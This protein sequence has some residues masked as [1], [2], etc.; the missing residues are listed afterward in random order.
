MCDGGKNHHDEIWNDDAQDANITRPRL[1]QVRTEMI[2]KARWSNESMGR[3]RT[4]LS[5][6]V[7][8]VKSN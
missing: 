4:A 8:G 3:A 7:I 5:P 2:L 6:H 1:G